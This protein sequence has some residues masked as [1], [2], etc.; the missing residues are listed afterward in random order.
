MYTCVSASFLQQLHVYQGSVIT[1]ISVSFLHVDA[2]IIKVPLLIFEKGYT[3][4]ANEYW[5][6]QHDFPTLQESSKY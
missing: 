1:P 4:T 5:Y 3:I 6:M 2:W